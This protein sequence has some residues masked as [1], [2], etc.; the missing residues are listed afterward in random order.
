MTD[1]RNWHFDIR[2]VVVVFPVNGKLCFQ[3]D[4]T[5]YTA[6]LKKS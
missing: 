5:P 1:D 2:N 3:E 4:I 6:L